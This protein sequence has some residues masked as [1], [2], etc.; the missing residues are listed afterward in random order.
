M[1]N[2][3]NF[4]IALLNLPIAVL[5]GP[6][7]PLGVQRTSGTR[8][9]FEA[10]IPMCLGRCVTFACLSDS[11]NGVHLSV[12]NS[13][14]HKGTNAPYGDQNPYDSPALICVSY[15]V[16]IRQYRQPNDRPDR[17]KEKDTIVYPRERWAK[18]IH[19]IRRKQNQDDGGGYCGGDPELLV[20]LNLVSSCGPIT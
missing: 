2:D 4:D 15:G 5:A 14:L 16:L 7:I 10:V 17:A 11:Q 18:E 13:R 8:R 6:A 12:L 19:D 3:V 9:I 20:H 1:R